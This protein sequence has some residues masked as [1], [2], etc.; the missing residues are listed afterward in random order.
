MLVSIIL[1]AVILFV[2]AA[3]V[4]LLAPRLSGRRRVRPFL[5]VKWAHRGLHDIEKGCPENSLPAFEAAAR[6]G[7][8]IE[9]DIHLTRD[10]EIV[11][12][13]DDTFDRLCGQP[14]CVEETDYETMKKYSLG[15][16]TEKIP[17]LSEVLALVRGRVPLLIEVKLPSAD[18]K[19]CGK[20]IS[21]LEGY[22]G[23]YM[24]QSFNCLALRWLKKYHG[25]IPR[26]QLS[27]NLT[28]SDKT[29]HYFLRFC[30]KYLLSNFLCRPDFISYKWADR[31][32]PG[33]WAN[34]VLFGAPAAVW[35]LHGERDMHAAKRHF[36][37]FIFEMN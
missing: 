32:N 27:A 5:G 20:L 31:K 7:Y 6:S 2:I 28:R 1:L 24:I 16:T 9:L 21:E 37:M 11:V 36:D 18:T 35:T 19:I 26:G 34:R 4:F 8:G 14:G 23:K 30:V 17:T 33:F 25:E 13:H 12:F 3:L 15:G 29:P 22:E 10:G